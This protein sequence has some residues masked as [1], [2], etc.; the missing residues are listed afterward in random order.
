MLTALGSDGH[1]YA[2]KKTDG[3]VQ[4]EILDRIASTEK[5]L[6]Q[7]KTAQEAENIMRGF[8][9]ETEKYGIRYHA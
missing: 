4:A 8:L 2:V 7:V 6:L 3:F 5:E 9:K 1:V